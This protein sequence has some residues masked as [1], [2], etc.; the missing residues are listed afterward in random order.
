M[1]SA[2]DVNRV[3]WRCRRGSLELDVI[4]GGFLTNRYASL[5]A[6]QRADFERLLTHPDH[7]LIEWLDRMVSPPDDLKVIIDKIT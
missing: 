3:R 4:L 1:T 5:S 6:A 7:V 2:A